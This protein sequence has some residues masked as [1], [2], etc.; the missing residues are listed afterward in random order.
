MKN[1]WA[2]IAIYLT[3]FILG[4]CMF[5]DRAFYVPFET[6][7][8]P[9]RVEGYRIEERTIPVGDATLSAWV[10]EPMGPPI[11][12]TV[13][14]SHGNA[15]NLENHIGFADFLPLNGYRMVM[16][17]YRGYGAST[18]G[19]PTREKTIEDASTALDWTLNNYGKVW[20]VGQSLG[21]SISIYV[22]GERS[23]DIEGVIAIA[24]F[25]S[26]RAIARDVLGR[27][28][29][30]WPVKWPLGFL[31]SSGGDPV[32]RVEDISPKPL[33]IVHGESDEII[34]LRMGEELFD[35]AGDPKKFESIPRMG[36][37]DGWRSADR[38]FK[39]KILDLLETYNH[40][41]DQS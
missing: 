5:A 32:D 15:G 9:P 4:G 1:P 21:A 20:M 36:H 13:L 23:N 38:S 19:P 40:H 3:L 17:D 7:P 34:P 28:I 33:L 25:S 18:G 27:T 8:T 22:G 10:L 37:N 24:P 12:G 35:L 14:Y 31:V 41:R 30:L 26:Y 11:Q 6:P 16:Y 29:I 2:R 39:E